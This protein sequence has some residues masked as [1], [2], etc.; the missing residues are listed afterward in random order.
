LKNFNFN[1]VLL[2]DHGADD[3]LKL[4]N[5]IETFCKAKVRQSVNINVQEVAAGTLNKSQSMSQRN[6]DL[7]NNEKK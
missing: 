3:D 6:S 5:V 4:L 7:E 1:F 2:K